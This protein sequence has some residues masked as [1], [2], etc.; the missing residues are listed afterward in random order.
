MTLRV[1]ASRSLLQLPRRFMRH[2][3]HARCAL[4]GRCVDGRAAE[5]TRSYIV[6]RLGEAS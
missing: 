3:L 6:A 5:P 2:R 1:T 4:G